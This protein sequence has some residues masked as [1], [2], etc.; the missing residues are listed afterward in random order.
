M[1]MIAN[2]ALRTAQASELGSLMPPGVSATRVT[3][4]PMSST[5][6]ANAAHA[7]RRPEANAC[8]PVVALL[9]LGRCRALIA[10]PVSVASVPETLRR[11]ESQCP[12]WRRAICITPA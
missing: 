2:G 8:R 3:D 12:K 6:A 5:H 7:R 4:T 11:L 9:A 10:Q 1:A